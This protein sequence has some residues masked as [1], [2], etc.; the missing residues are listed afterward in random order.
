M[1][2]TANDEEED[3]DLKKAIELSIPTQQ[4]VEQKKVDDSPLIDL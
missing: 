4:P 2:T 3:D 1:S